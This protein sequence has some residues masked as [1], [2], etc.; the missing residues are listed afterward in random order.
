MRKYF[1]NKNI[2]ITGGLG[3]IGSNL[4]IKLLNENANIEIYDALI[5]N[6][7]GNLYN[8]DQIKKDI[9]VT[10]AD[11]RDEKKILRS[12]KN[13]DFIFNLAGNLSHVD[14]MSNPFMDL[15]INCRAQL[16]LLEACRKNNQGLRI[17]F[18][19]TRNQYGR[20]LYLPVDEKHI[21]EPTDVN[22]INSITAEKYHFLYYRVHGIRATSLRMS[23]VFGPRHQMK[24][25]RQGVLNWFLKQIME[26][27]LV[28]LF[29]D[30]SQIRDINYVSEVVDALILLAQTKSAWGEAFNIGGH[31]MSLLEFVKLAISVRGGGNYKLVQF[32]KNRKN[33]EIG[34]Y[35]A[36]I[37]KIKDATGW[38]PSVEPAVGLEKTYDYYES[39]L[40][41]YI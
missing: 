19:G 13:K 21:Q 12:V 34:N 31:P 2:L 40:K 28:K 26:G 6:F 20:A 22:G 8:V 1:K 9:K 24:H 17:I 29:G 10:V 30:G 27:E 35:V 33:I 36:D 38:S 39:R 3:F 5:G 23:N 16:C 37:K 18:A 32:P 41:Y 15:D 25:S 11:L 4:A 7:G 14:S